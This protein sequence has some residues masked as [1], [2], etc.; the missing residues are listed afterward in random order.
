M[1]KSSSLDVILYE[2]IFVGDTVKVKRSSKGVS[3]T[4]QLSG[5]KAPLTL[6]LRR[7][8]QMLSSRLCMDFV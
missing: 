6:D 5:I 8:F 2:L 1:N 3:K 4:E 7:K